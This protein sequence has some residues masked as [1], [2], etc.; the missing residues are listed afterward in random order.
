MPLDLDDAV[1][2]FVAGV[3]G[4]LLGYPLDTIKVH[5]Q[6]VAAHA[7]PRP[8]LLAAA[9]QIR[10]ARGLAGFY[11]GVLVPLLGV[12][13]LNTLSF[14]LY[15][16]FRVALGLPP[17]APP[18]AV[19]ERT[20]SGELDARVALAGGLIGPFASLISTPMD[21]LKIQMQ[22][23]RHA[24]TLGAAREIVCT[25]GARA[26]YIGL[27]VNVLREVAFGACYFGAYE[28]ARGAVAQT[29]A[30]PPLAVPLAG[31]IGGVCGWGA[32]LPFDTIKSV[33]QAGPVR[34]G[35]VRDARQIARD[36]WAAHG[37]RGFM[38]GARASMLRAMLVSGTRF[39]AYEAALDAMRARGARARLAA[40]G[41][42]GGEQLAAPSRGEERRR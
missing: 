1:A 39:S 28:V 15:A 25:G 11:A 42:G 14:T 13:A 19:A 41:G 5:Q 36:I 20:A 31:A 22:Q 21:L 30:P 34:P 8:S 33:Q 38:S 17:R 23:Q 27:P 6:A 37:A 10:A 12:T 2:G 16:H 35:C 32:S 7:G 18:G 29:G 26:M 40:G 9:R 3:V 4:T 24:S